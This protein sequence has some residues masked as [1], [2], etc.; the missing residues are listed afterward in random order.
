MP[1]GGFLC[2]YSRQI[3]CKV[4]AEELAPLDVAWS[5]TDPKQ[6]TG[7]GIAMARALLRSGQRLAPVMIRGD[8]AGI[9]ERHRRE[10]V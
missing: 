2:T 3:D 5:A 1:S 4:L 6:I 8:P 10:T 7:P 9:V